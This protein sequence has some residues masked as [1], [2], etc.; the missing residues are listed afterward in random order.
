L[1]RQSRYCEENA[2]LLS[3][4][5]QTSPEKLAV[6]S[7]RMNDIAMLKRVAPTGDRRL[8]L[9]TEEG[10]RTELPGQITE[11]NLTNAI[12]NLGRGKKK[13]YFLSGHG[14]PTLTW[15]GE[16]NYAALSE[17]LKKRGYEPQEHKVASG[18]LPADAQVVVAGSAL[19]AYPAFVETML[20]K[21]LVKG[22]KLILSVNP[23]REFGLSKLL[24]DIGVNLDP[25]VLVGDGGVTPLGAQLAQANPMRA[26]V[27]LGE[28]SRSSDVTSKLSVPYGVADGARSISV[29]DVDKNGLKTRSSELVSAFAATSFSLSEQERNRISLEAPF[30]LQG[31][32]TDA[33]RT[34]KV[35]Y[36]IEIENPGKLASNNENKGEK[37]EMIVLGFELISKYVPPEAS[38]QVEMP[39]LAVAQFH[40]DKELV[41][42][43]TKDYAPKQFRMDKN[44]G[45]WLAAFAFF[46]P[47]GTVLMGLYIWLRRRAA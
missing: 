45:S 11:S 28:F 8:V 12:I 36:S 3:L 21:F 25:V 1:Q 13:V 33:K 15:D 44:P 43:P 19:Q 39:L 26:P 31:G 5:A 34:Y 46:L 23:Y 6:G 10:A 4:F 37:A 42:I 40:K 9:V 35:A 38:T 41:N 18:D 14:E 22:G 29:K 27:A 30:A 17:F 16:R 2:H 47:V 20:R 32:Q 7:V 24:A